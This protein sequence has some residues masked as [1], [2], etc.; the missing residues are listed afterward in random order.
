IPIGYMDQLNFNY[1]VNWNNSGGTKVSMLGLLALNKLAPNPRAFYCPALQD[2]Q[3]NYNTPSNAWPDFN[4]WPNDPHFL[5]TNQG[6]TRI[7][8]MTRP[9]ANWPTNGR[10][11]A[12][13]P[14][15]EGYWIP[16]LGTNWTASST[17]ILVIAM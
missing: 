16:Y 3:W 5:F 4:N 17:S 1:F 13:T 10:T 11:W 15:K 2:E 7:N 8:Y 12:S 14:D 9:I 6:H